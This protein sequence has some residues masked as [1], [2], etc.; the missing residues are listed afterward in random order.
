MY[1]NITDITKNK[2]VKNATKLLKQT[3]FEKKNLIQE[4][5]KKL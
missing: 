5:N 4:M 3:K 1:K 2:N